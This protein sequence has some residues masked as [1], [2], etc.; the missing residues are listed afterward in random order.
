MRELTKT[1]LK[2]IS[3]G[4]EVIVVTGER[5]QS[6][7]EKQLIMDAL[8]QDFELY[9]MGEDSVFGD[10]GGGSGEQSNEGDDCAGYDGDGDG[11]N[12]STPSNTSDI[13]S[14]V[15]STANDMATASV[16]YGQTSGT[17]QDF[18]EHGAL[19]VRDIFG[20]IQVR[21]VYT[22]GDTNSVTVDLG[23]L[24]PGDTVVG[25]IHTQPQGNAASSG[26]FDAMSA[27]QEQL[28]FTIGNSMDPDALMYIVDPD[29]NV[30]EF[31]RSMQDQGGDNVEGQDPNAGGNGNC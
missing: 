22:N 1:E 17:G 25:V 14:A 19:I 15:N 26:D 29:G 9:G 12:D 20:N 7:W 24:S 16:E 21:D 2:S 11:Q 3:G 28:L 6:D 23:T 27:L 18:A 31:T 13:R 4:A 30:A 10:G 8:S 5:I